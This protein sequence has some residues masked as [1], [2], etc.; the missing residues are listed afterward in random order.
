MWD[1]KRCWVEIFSGFHLY[2]TSLPHIPALV[3]SELCPAF[4]GEAADE[5]AC[6]GTVND[7][8]TGDVGGAAGGATVLF[9][10]PQDN[11]DIFMIF[12]LG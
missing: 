2:L 7:P 8:L 12:L 5:G 4:R 3:A 1:I 10:R 9:L 11:I 6:Y